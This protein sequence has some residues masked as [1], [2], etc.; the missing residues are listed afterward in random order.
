VLRVEGRYFVDPGGRVVL[1]RGVNL[2]GDAKLPP[3]LPLDDPAALDPLPALGIN[4][5]RLLF[6]W[7]AYEPQ[8]GAYDERYLAQVVAIAWEAW[9]RGLYVI[10]DFH[11]DGVSR[12]VSRGCGAGF[13]AWAISPRARRVETDNGLA[14]KYWP[15][16]MMTDPNMHRALTDFYADTYGARSR[17][18]AMLERVAGAFAG[19]P[20]VVGYDMF[21]EPW[22]FERTELAPLYRDAAAALRSRHPTAILFVAGHGSTSCGLQTRLPRPEFDNFAYA[23][24]AYRA[25]AVALNAWYGFTRPIDRHFA[26][27]RAKADEWGVPLFVGEFGIGGDARRGGDLVA[28]VYDRL[29][30]ALASGAQWNYTPRWNE[31]DRDGWNCEDYS[32]LDDRAC[33]RPNFRIRPYPQKIA[34]VPTRFCFQPPGDVPARWECSWNHDPQRGATEVFTPSAL[35]PAGSILAVDPPDVVCTRD[36]ARQLL[37]VRAPRATPVTVSLTAP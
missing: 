3:F 13:P 11:Q 32:I 37:I 21:N 26:F 2:S 15:L 14:C 30:A 28:A 35:F 22:G 1:L 4:A 34:G 16:L 10:V 20:G 12:W 31:H 6:I 8:P 18:L 9:R 25:L 29:D 19:C 24:H 36:D 33:V 7:E 5:V 17:Y 27:M 23:P